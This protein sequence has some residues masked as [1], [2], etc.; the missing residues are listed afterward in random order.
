M[1]Q[2]SPRTDAEF[3]EQA[4]PWSAQ[5][6]AR[7]LRPTL[8]RLYLWSAL[9]HLTTVALVVLPLGTLLLTIDAYGDRG[10]YEW[11]LLGGFA[12]MAALAFLAE[13][14]NYHFVEQRKALRQSIADYPEAQQAA[15]TAGGFVL[16]LRG[17]GEETDLDVAGTVST[18]PLDALAVTVGESLLPH[19]VRG[20]AQQR[21]LPI[22]ALGNRKT[23]RNAEGVHFIYSDHADWER[24]FGILLQR[25]HLVVISLFKS[26]RA[27]LRD[28]RGVSP[29]LRREIETLL[30]DEEALAKTLVLHLDHQIE[31]FM[32]AYVPQLI[33]RAH[34]SVELET[35]LGH[36]ASEQTPVAALPDD[37]SH[38][39]AEDGFPSPT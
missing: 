32:P 1:A 10:W 23:V 17:F 5:L 14:R 35:K 3:L 30:S 2:A 18:D 13:Y 12:L 39:S 20:W 6:Y 36:A 9:C 34:W 29:G 11:T 4:L 8:R 21:G 16:Y 37:L 22:L 26:T 38:W 24:L 28:Y 33:E 31:D 25:S 27:L 19:A 15:L 7:A